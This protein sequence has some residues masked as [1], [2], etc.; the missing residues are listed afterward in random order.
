MSRFGRSPGVSERRSGNIQPEQCQAKRLPDSDSPGS[1]GYGRLY[2]HREMG[3]LS[4]YSSATLI[5]ELPKQDALVG[6]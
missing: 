5:R 3:R 1:P 4:G 6:E 2:P